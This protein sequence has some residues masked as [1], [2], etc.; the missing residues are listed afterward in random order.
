MAS[1]RPCPRE[2]DPTAD[3]SNARGAVACEGQP[4]ATSRIRWT[5]AVLLTLVGGGKSCVDIMKTALRVPY[6]SYNTILPLNKWKENF[7]VIRSH[8]AS[9]N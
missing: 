8:S 3:R 6:L 4:L 2:A 5:Y 7:I 1:I 9:V